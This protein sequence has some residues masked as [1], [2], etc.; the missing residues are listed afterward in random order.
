MRT[1]QFWNQYNFLIFRAGV[2]AIYWRS[3]WK[4]NL[5]ENVEGERTN[6]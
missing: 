1:I 6:V 4:Q 2:L 3:F 5:G